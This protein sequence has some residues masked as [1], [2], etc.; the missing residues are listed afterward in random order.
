[1]L[2]VDHLRVL[3]QRM[4]QRTF[5]MSIQDGVL[6]V[7]R[8]VNLDMNAV[9]DSLTAYPAFCDDSDQEHRRTHAEL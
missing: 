5:R 7:R 6:I 4:T 8:N 1:M 2:C 9:A 3:L